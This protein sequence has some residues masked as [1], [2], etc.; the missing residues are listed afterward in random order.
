MKTGLAPVYNAQTK[1]LI[2]GSAPSEKSLM[3]QQ[4]Y[5]NKSNRFWSILFDCLQV[6]DPEDYQKRLAI[7]LAHRIGLWDVYHTF[8]RSGSMDHQYGTVERNDFSAFLQAAP[9]ETVIANGKKAFQEAQK[10][11]E[12]SNYPLISCLSTSG[13]NN[14]KT[15][16]RLSQW[17]RVF[18]ELT[19]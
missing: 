9:I 7:L 15:K 18:N 6:A 13:A 14:A 2:L 1:I 4:Y 11:P 10:I 3:R 5:G 12:L 16:E 17:K 8:E 19:R